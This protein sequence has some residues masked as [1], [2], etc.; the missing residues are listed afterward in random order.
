MEKT[1]R[2]ASDVQPNQVKAEKWHK[3]WWLRAKDVVE[4]GGGGRKV[5]KRHTN[6]PG[7]C[8]Y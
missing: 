1:A 3:E 7:G 4:E 5:K 6:P 2:K 8:F